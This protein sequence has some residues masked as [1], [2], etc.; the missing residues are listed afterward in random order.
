MEISIMLAVAALMIAARLGVPALTVALG[1][2]RAIRQ[3]AEAARR[4]AEFAARRAAQGKAA[5]GQT[6]H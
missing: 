1:K 4:A 2:R 3:R 5:R 6:A